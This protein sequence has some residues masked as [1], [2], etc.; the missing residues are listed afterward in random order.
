MKWDII[1]YGKR[2]PVGTTQERSPDGLWT[3]ITSA[4]GNEN[5]TSA[6]DLADGNKIWFD[7][8]L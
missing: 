6:N 1:P 8:A 5:D 4:H 2:L 3:D 7:H